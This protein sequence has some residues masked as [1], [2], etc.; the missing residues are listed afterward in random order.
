MTSLHRLTS[1][2]RASAESDSPFRLPNLA[3]VAARFPFRSFHS[4]RTSAIRSVS[5]TSTQLPAPVVSP[6]TISYA[7]LSVCTHASLPSFAK[8]HFRFAGFQMCAYIDGSSVDGCGWWQDPSADVLD[9][10]ELGYGPKG[11]GILSVS[12]VWTK[13]SRICV[14]NQKYVCFYFVWVY[15][16]QDDRWKCFPSHSQLLLEWR[17]LV[18]IGLLTYR[19]QLIIN[20]FLNSMFVDVPGTL[21]SNSVC[22]C[23][24]DA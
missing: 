12:D 8:A 22:W 13:F 23:I 20:S 11:L 16:L 5:E 15:L 9:K 7:E 10:I 2:L 18:I 21:N 4:P 24:R 19:K 3:A 17:V 14:L 6:V 1:L